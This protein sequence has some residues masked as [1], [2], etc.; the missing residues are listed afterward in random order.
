MEQWVKDNV[1]G[2]ARDYAILYR[3]NNTEK[4]KPSSK[5]PSPTKKYQHVKSKIAMNLQA[6]ERAAIQKEKEILG[7]S[8]DPNQD[9]MFVTNQALLDRASNYV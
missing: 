7:L 8:E 5:P 3:K 2:I 1:K 4:K 6:Q 9:V